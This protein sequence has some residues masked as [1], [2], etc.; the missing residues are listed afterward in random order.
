MR[1][2]YDGP[3]ITESQVGT[4]PWATVEQWVAEAEARQAAQ[5][6]TPEPRALSVA[7]IDA[8]GVPD[9]RTVLMRFLD[10]RGPG[11]VTNLNSTKGEQ[12]AATPAIAA[13][14]TWPGMFRAVRFRGVAEL[15]EAEEVEAYFRSRPWGS[16][17][18]AWVSEQS[19]PVENRQ[20]LEDRFAE[21]AQRWPDTGSPDDVP[22]PEHWGAYRVRSI[23]V[24]LW[25]GR[26]SRVHDRL[27][28]A[29][30]TPGDLDAGGWALQRLQP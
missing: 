2:E 15:V 13:S 12:L 10:P 16:R 11:F 27:R 22:R 6:D 21:Y 9:V 18:S 28:F 17:I 5:G 25:A 23:S 14:L 29:R 26:P 20:V 30:A 1:Q 24:E 3:G 4:S 8:G 7:T 19:Q